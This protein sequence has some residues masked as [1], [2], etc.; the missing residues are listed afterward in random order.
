MS[1]LQDIGGYI[2]SNISELTLGTNLFLSLMPESPDNCVALLEEGGVE[3][4]Y[5]QGSNHLPVIE[6]PQL[7]IIVRNFSYETG[8]ALA[9]QLYR[10]LSLANT[11]INGV[12]YLRIAPISSPFIIER[13]S[14]KRP[15]I[16]CNFHVQRIVP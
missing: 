11:S 14:A 4:L 2:D 10:L 1:L 6:Q 15:V 5:T 3:P 8:R 12:Q 13:D 16:S 9:E 7:Q